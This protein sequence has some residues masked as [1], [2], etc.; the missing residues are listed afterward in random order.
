MNLA[1]RPYAA[2]SLKCHKRLVRNVLFV[3]CFLLIWLTAAPFPD[4]GDARLLEPTGEGNP[5]SQIA[6]FLLT[7]VL[8][9]FIFS[10]A[11]RVAFRAITP[12]LIMTLSW[13]TLTAVLS[14]HPEMAL[15]RLALA[16]FTVAN[17]IALLLLPAGREHFGRLL[18]V[19]A[20]VLLAICYAGVLLL[21]QL[22]IHQSTDV[23]EYNLAG[24]WRGPFGH[25]NS[26]GASMVMLIFIGAFVM[27]TASRIAGVLIIVG[28]SI[29]L[30]F[31][32]SKSPIGFLPL[33]S[34][35]AFV[36]MRLRHAAAKYALVAG[37]LILLNLLTV[38]TVVIEPIRNLVAGLMSDSSFT[39]RDEIWRFAL[40][41]ALERPLAGFGFQAFWRTPELVLNWGLNESWGLRASDAHNGY[42]NIA[43]TTGLVGL[44]LSLMWIVALPLADLAAVTRN[45]F[46]S[47]LTLLFAQI[48]IFGLCVS[49]VESVLFSGGDSLWFMMIV[50]IIGLRLQKV[51]QLAR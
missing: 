49:S 47:P 51:A 45:G 36:V 46:D 29:F 30:C 17:A 13:F 27:R 38:G 14:A 50:S 28:A 33:A 31:T 34:V 18:A 25:K 19:S 22:S 9:A 21:P 37:A 23:L 35:L 5:V 7:V 32:M 26:A 41:H 15:R 1:L 48:W 10:A 20:L 39:G 11:P 16:V 42:L 6:I 3:A 44:V 43:V 24:A 2:G 8:S 4:L 40:E 12:A